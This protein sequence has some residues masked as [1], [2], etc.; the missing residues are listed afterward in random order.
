MSNPF[1]AAFDEI[2]HAAFAD[3]G[4][5]DAGLYR[6]APAAGI[7][8]RVMIDRAPVIQGEVSGSYSSVPEASIMLA[9]VP[10]PQ[11]GA[12]LTVGTESWQLEGEVRRDESIARF[13]LGPLPQVLDL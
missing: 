9:D 13:V 12:I 11:Q 6:L 4:L 10:D 1:L 5:A 8:C 2:A 3:A 7:A